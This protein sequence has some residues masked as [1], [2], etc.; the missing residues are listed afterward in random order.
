MKIYPYM[1]A[2]ERR[3]A[4]RWSDTTQAHCD[5][6]VDPT[7]LSLIMTLLVQN[8]DAKR[9]SYE[10]SDVYFLLPNGD[11]VEF[12]DEYY[13]KSPDEVTFHEMLEERLR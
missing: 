11:K 5:F 1:P 2:E 8:K 3:Y 9:S 6:K 10:S 12:S 7:M 4:V 13:K